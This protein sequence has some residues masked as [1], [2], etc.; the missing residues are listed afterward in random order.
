MDDKT[1]F[2]RV[3][4][5]DTDAFG[6]VMSRYAPAL[7]SFAHRIVGECQAAEDITQEVF[8]NFWIR[9]RKLDAGPSLRNFLYLSVRNSA[10]NHIRMQKN[11]TLHTDLYRLEQ[12]M[13]LFVVEE[14]TYR[15]LAEAVDKLPPRTAEVIRLSM[16]GLRQEEIAERMGVTVANVKLLKARGIQKLR[17][18]LG[19]LSFILSIVNPFQ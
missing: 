19:P 14:E 17:E 16:E 15:L 12:T 13:G 1:L 9:R 3:T 18:I 4:R 5:D 7:Y 10:L 2:E 11:H 6:D 8:M